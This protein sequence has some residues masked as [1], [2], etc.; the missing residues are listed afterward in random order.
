MSILTLQQ[1]AAELGRIRIG[2]RQPTANGKTR[3]AKLDTFRLTSPSRTLIE[4]AARLYGGTVSPWSPSATAAGQWE[5]IT[6]SAE[7]PIMV[8]PRPLSQWY[9]HWSGGGCLRRCDGERETLSGSACLCDPDPQQRLCK[10]TTRLSVVL[11]DM[12]G[13][14]LWRLETHGH[15]AAVELPALAEFL[16]DTRGYLPAALV[17]R[18]R[19]ALR[20]DPRTGKSATLRYMVPGIEVDATPAQ[21]MAARPAT[22]IEGGPVTVPA[23]GPLPAIQASDD[24]RAWVDTITAVTDMRT[25]TTVY[26]AVK[27]EGLCP[28]MADVANPVV[29]ALV[30]ARDR[31]RPALAAPVTAPHANAAD[32][33][34]SVEVELPLPPE[35]SEAPTTQDVD[36]LWRLILSAAPQE[37]STSDIEAD[38]ES[39]TGVS[40]AVATAAHMHQY[41]TARP[42]T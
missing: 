18:E 14:G 41:R 16:A 28:D 30:A 27:G 5:V 32:V 21:I 39:V 3:P 12:P 15:Y 19:T 26:E 8:P 24:V 9:E 22:A 1:R 20:I 38:F 2:V 11:R 10:A 35:D 13:I 31:L 37:M 25:L 36:E 34:R 4:H 40:A 17:V 7:L 23:V 33:V 6:D 29:A 42:N